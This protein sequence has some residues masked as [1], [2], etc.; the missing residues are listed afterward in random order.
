MVSAGLPMYASVSRFTWFHP[1]EA[2]MP[3]FSP[4][5]SEPATVM[6]RVVSMAFRLA[7]PVR[8][9]VARPP[10]L[11]TVSLSIQLK[12]RTPRRAKFLAE[13]PETPM[14][15]AI[16]SFSAAI[17]RLLPNRTTPSWIRAL[18]SLLYR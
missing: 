4:R 13:P 5:A 17:A 18:A 15:M 1:I 16:T 7:S 2:P 3:T 8:V 14:S 6:T 9:T 10:T 12:R 11:A